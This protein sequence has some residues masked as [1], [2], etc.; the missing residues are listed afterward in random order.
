MIKRGQVYFNHYHDAMGN[1]KRLPVLV[2]SGDEY[3]GRSQFV[4]CVRL[5][6][7]NSGVCPQHVFI[8]ANAFSETQ[9][10]SDC[11]ALAETINSTRQTSMEGPI[12]VLASDYYMSAVGDAIKFQVGLAMTEPYQP[13]ARENQTGK[14][15]STE[16]PWYSAALRA[17]ENRETRETRGTIHRDSY[18]DSITKMYGHIETGGQP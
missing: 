7:Y 10:L 12:G 6:K 15:P 11:Y 16:A 2:V 4:T 17:D 18:N 1:E 3:N 5:A 8:P 14:R 9:I 13:M